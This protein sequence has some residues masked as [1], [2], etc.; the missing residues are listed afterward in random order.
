MRGK[1]KS[2]VNLADANLAV[3]EKCRDPERGTTIFFCLGMRA[4]T[5]WAATEYLIRN[6]KHLVA[7]FGDSN[8]VVCLG[9]PKTEEY[10]DEYKE[11]L[12]VSMGGR[13]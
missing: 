7:E 5:S 13:R 12:R 10:L 2:E 1:S 4:D 8:F 6:W 9:F 11:P 3:V